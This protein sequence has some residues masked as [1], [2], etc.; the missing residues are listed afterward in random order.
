MRRLR[1]GVLSEL[2][3][4]LPLPLLLLLEEELVTLFLP[5][6]TL[7][8]SVTNTIYTY[9]KYIHTYIHAY[10]HIHTYILEPSDTAI[11][12]KVLRF[13]KIYN[14]LCPLLFTVQRNYVAGKVLAN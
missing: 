6:C 10:I 5:C 4:L 1:S 12:D 11:S 3:S 7:L 2:L 8:L 13:D 14:T 9:I